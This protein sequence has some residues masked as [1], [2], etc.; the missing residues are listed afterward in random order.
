MG[1]GRMLSAE[2]PPEGHLTG[3][4]AWARNLHATQ[5]DIIWDRKLDTQAVVD[6]V[7]FSE[8]EDQFQ[9]GTTL[10]TIES[11]SHADICVALN[12]THRKDN[13]D[14][15]NTEDTHRKTTKV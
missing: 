10:H 14:Q 7:D 6:L 3:S 9:G 1:S 4:L 2:D 8:E 12:E 15:R 11:P 5:P 13:I